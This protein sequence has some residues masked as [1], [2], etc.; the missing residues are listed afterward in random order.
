MF[1]EECLRA[2]PTLDFIKAT[3]PG[4]RAAEAGEVAGGINFLCST[5]ATYINDVGLLVDA[6]LTL[7]V[8]LS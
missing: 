4:G 8:H 2:P 3:V 1:T 5:A 7:T 6:G